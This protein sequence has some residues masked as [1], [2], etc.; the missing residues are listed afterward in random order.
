LSAAYQFTAFN[1]SDWNFLFH[2]EFLDIE[3][4]WYN[5]GFRYYNALLGRWLSR[6]PLGEIAGKNLYSF[7]ENKATNF[8]DIY[9]LEIKDVATCEAKL[10]IGHS[11][12]SDP[13]EWHRF[14]KCSIAGAVSCWPAAN[15]PKDTRSGVDQAGDE[16]GTNRFPNPIWPF[17]PTHG[18]KLLGSSLGKVAAKKKST[19]DAVENGFPEGDARSEHDSAIAIGN[20]LSKEAME[21]IKKRL[22]KNCCTV[23][24]ITIEVGKDKD[25]NEI[26]KAVAPFGLKPGQTKS[27]VIQCPKS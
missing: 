27:T 16:D 24:R 19:E 1:S 20:A 2:G 3:T 25:T 23:I 6:D 8:I 22:C 5:Y 9:G 15:S 11:S 26:E 17:I 7:V 13:I 21:E 4:V 12:L 14:G 10:Y 18:D